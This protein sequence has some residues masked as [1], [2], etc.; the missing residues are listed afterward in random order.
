L[1]YVPFFM[2]LLSAALSV[3]LNI[4]PSGVLLLSRQGLT[5]DELKRALGTLD[6]EL[7]RAGAPCAPTEETTRQL[8]VAGAADPSTCAGKSA[9]LIGLVSKLKLGWLVTVSVSKLG[10]DRAWVVEAH[11][12]AKGT[13]VAREDWLDETNADVSEPTARIAAKLAKLIKASDAPVATKLEPAPVI[14]SAPVITQPIEPAAN[15]LPKVLLVGAGV[16]GA[17]A[18]GLAI[19][20]GATAGDLARTQPGPDNLKLSPYTPKQAQDL[21]DT[22]NALSAGAI[23]AGVVAAGLGAGAYFTW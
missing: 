19:G 4:D 18:I 12:V 13:T 14:V 9:C 3:A 8:K 2:M 20:A 1:G 7:T 5:N 6:A 23:I 22:S 10:N 17:A 16:A 15:V 21:A 11:D